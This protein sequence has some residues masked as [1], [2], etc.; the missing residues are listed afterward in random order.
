MS[1]AATWFS[2]HTA[3]APSVLVARAWRFLELSSE[4]DS[5]ADALAT[6]GTAA[7]DTS[8]EAGAGRD[9]ALDLLA[10]DAL[11]TLALLECA[12][13]EPDRLGERA[14]ELRFAVT[15]GGAP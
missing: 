3:G 9:A 1:E 2:A 5:V 4:I 13:R 12:E 14:R 7:L 11:I 15:S 8:I 6:A 10:A